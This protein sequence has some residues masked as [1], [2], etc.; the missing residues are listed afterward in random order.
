MAG[1][2]VQRYDGWSLGAREQRRDALQRLARGVE[3]D[4]FGFL[5]RE[6]AF[7]AADE[8]RRDLPSHGIDRLARP[9]QYGLALENRLESAQAVGLERRA[10]RHE[11]ADV[12]GDLEPRGEL[13]RTFH[14]DHLS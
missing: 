2:A 13:D 5:G 11:I 3:H 4:V 14:F 1:T 8:L 12:G 10:G 7:D 6:H 9:D